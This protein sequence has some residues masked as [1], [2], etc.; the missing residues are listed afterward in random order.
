MLSCQD[1]GGFSRFKNLS[2]E[3][4]E[5]RNNLIKTVLGEQAAPYCTFCNEDCD[6]KT[7]AGDCM[8]GE[9]LGTLQDGLGRH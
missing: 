2:F 5:D 8:D 9:L 6:K 4:K 7:L 1:L 3:E